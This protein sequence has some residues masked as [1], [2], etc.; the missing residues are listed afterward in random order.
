MTCQKLNVVSLGN[1]GY[2]SREGDSQI[3]LI[4]DFFTLAKSA[5]LFFWI[6]EVRQLAAASDLRG[7]AG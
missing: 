2:S 3:R 4:P 5:S 7:G 1:F 6:H